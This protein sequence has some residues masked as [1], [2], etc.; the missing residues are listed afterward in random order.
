[1][2]DAERLTPLEIAVAPLERQVEELSD[3][4]RDQADAIDRLGAQSRVL[5]TRL[6]AAEA[7][8][9]E[10]APDPNQPPPHW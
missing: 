7:A 10:D 5:A 9:P 4:L 2:T 3:L 6:A 8:L 1:M